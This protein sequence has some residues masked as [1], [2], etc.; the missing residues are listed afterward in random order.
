[1]DTIS[2]IGITVLDYFGNWKQLHYHAKRFYAPVIVAGI[3]KTPENI[4]IQMVSDLQNTLQGELTLSVR[5]I[6][7]EIRSERKLSVSIAASSVA[8][9]ESIPIQEFADSPSENFLYLEFH[10]ACSGV[11]VQCANECFFAKYKEYQLPEPAI[12]SK[13]YRDSAGMTH[14]SL[15]TD[16][17]AFYVFAEI[18]GIRGVFSDNSFT[19]LPDKP[20]DLTLRTDVELG[21]EELERALTIQH[22]RGS[23]ED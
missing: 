23:Y 13:I 7:G 3:R 2:S 1:M 15:S 20:R 19:L 4:E 21:L 10:G 9:L 14:L 6:S 16:K 8:V 5:K 22:L 11:P 17:A 12:K 18:K